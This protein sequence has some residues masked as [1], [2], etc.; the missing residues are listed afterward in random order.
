[1][2]NTFGFGTDTTNFSN[3]VRTRILR[4]VIDTLRAGLIALPKGAVV[5][6]DLVAQNG[7]TFTLRAT[8]Y[9]DLVDAAVTSP[10]AEGTP[11][12]AVKLGISTNDWTVAQVGAYTKV[13]DLAQFQN[14]HDLE[15]VAS[16]KIAR[17]AVQAIDSLALTAIRAHAVDT[18]TT[19]KLS[20]DALVNAVARLRGKDME[21]AADGLFYALCHPFALAGLMKEASLN[22]WVDAAKHGNPASLTRGTAGD[23][24]GVRFLTSTR[25]TPM[26]GADVTLSNPSAAAD[27]IIDTTAAHGFVA[28]DRVRFTALTGGAGLSTNTDYYVIAANLA[29]QT[30]QVS[31]TPGGTAVNF[32][33]DITAGTVVLFNDVVHFL[34]KGS[35]AFGD[36]RTIEPLISRG[37]T[38]EN[39]LA[40]YSTVGFKGILGGRVFSFAETADGAGANSAAVDRMWTISVQSDVV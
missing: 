33:T 16:D 35:L 9:P 28:G 32:T 17:L 36:V 10:L 7:E 12:T 22:G 39:P 27:D 40:Q 37:P 25:I 4:N 24:R 3:T 29:A 8:E 13:T 31:A 21:P 2:P 14:P 23:Y 6:G 18:R 11:P 30:F 15:R 26:A 38:T 19:A 1:M 34:G 5:P 20:T